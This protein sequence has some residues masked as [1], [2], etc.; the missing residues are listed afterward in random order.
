MV[1]IIAF[2]LSVTSPGYDHIAAAIAEFNDVESY[3]VTLRST[4]SNHS[5]KIRYYF[6]KP[7]FVRMEFLEPY[8]GAVIV[9]DPSRKKVRLRP[10]G[11]LKFFVLTLSPDSRFVESSR[12][13]RV[14]ESDIGSLLKLV[15]KLQSN[16]ESKT[17]K[18]GT[19]RDRKALLVSVEGKPDFTVDGVHRYL[20]WFDR[21]ILL[22]LKVSAY[23]SA[24]KLIE[25]VLMDDLHINPELSENLFDL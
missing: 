11:F 9:Y 22:P 1:L 12:G 10:F 5:E 6:K 2:M 24:G 4:G 17:L 18:E 16:G 21:K 20:L 25:E 8:K 7:G 15:E 13:H 14:D 19:I 3:S 23:D